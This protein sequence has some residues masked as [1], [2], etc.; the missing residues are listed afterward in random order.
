MQPRPGSKR[1]PKTTPPDE[2]HRETP[3]PDLGR[4]D[5]SGRGGAPDLAAKSD[6]E[7]EHA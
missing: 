7:E 4:T 1:R 3:G 5:D 2:E 6:T